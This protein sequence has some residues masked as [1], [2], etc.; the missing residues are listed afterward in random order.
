MDE[1]FQ[2]LWDELSKSLAMADD[3]H[4][5][6]LRER[7]L[8]TGTNLLTAWCEYISRRSSPSR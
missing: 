4:N 5:V 7:L 8:H 6:E 2:K 3:Q 1:R